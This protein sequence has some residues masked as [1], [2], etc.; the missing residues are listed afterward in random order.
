MSFPI[1]IPISFFHS[2]TQFKNAL[3]PLY[4]ISVGLVIVVTNLSL[5]LVDFMIFFLYAS[6]LSYVPP[7]LKALHFGPDGMD[8]QGWWPAFDLWSP[9][10]EGENW[11]PPKMPSQFYTCTRPTFMCISH[12]HTHACTH[13]PTHARRHT[14]ERCGKMLDF[15]VGL[16]TQERIFVLGMEWLLL[17]STVNLLP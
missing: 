5:Y 8:Q 2:F 1:N 7:S 11:P 6:V 10:V 12:I 16:E 13:A 14:S 9:H 15:L 4:T 17:W 3:E